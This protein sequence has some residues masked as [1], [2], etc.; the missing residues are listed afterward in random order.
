M[1]YIYKI[2]NLING[3]MYIG[4]TSSS[5]EKRWREHISDSQKERCEKRPLY[6]AF[7]KYGIKNFQIEEVEEVENDDIAC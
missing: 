5:I 1:S 7:N 2:T 3:K 4:K 6:D